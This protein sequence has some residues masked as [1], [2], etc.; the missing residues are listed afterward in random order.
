MSQVIRELSGVILTRAPKLCNFVEWRGFKVVYKRYASLYFCMCIDQGDNELE[1][2]QII[3]HFVEILDRYFGNVCE[4]DL[5]FN[6]HKAYFILD[7][8][9]IA[10]ELQESSKRTIAKLIDAQDSLVEIAK[11]QASSI[12]NMIA[13]VTK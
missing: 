4:L 6:F 8:I 12:S 2:L 11:E 1:V 3:H 10:G 5:I 13:Q 9:L 7:E